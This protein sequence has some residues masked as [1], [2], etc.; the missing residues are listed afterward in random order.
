MT[1]PGM[2]TARIVERLFE[3][4]DDIVEANGKTNAELAQLNA[5]MAEHSD[6][7]KR[8]M[9]AVEGNGSP[10]LKQRMTTIE[11]Y[12]K[13]VVWALAPLYGAVIAWLVNHFSK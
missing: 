8:L 6:D 3:R 11:S 4:I 1:E 9:D 13:V 5:R 12:H 7:T 2:N 10:G